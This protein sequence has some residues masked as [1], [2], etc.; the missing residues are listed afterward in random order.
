M[1]ISRAGGTATAAPLFTQ[2]YGHR[3]RKISPVEFARKELACLELVDEAAESFA[4]GRLAEFDARVGDRNCQILTHKVVDLSLD[5]GF[6]AATRR[7]AAR[8]RA[9]RPV[10]DGYAQPRPRSL[11]RLLAEAEQDGALL[12]LA[13]D[14]VLLANSYA[15]KK[16][17]RD[18]DHRC[19][20]R[21]RDIGGRR[22]F[23]RARRSINRL[24]D[25]H[26]TIVARRAWEYWAER[27]AESLAE[28]ARAIWATLREP[29]RVDAFYVRPHYSGLVALLHRI[30]QQRICIAVKSYVLL[31]DHLHV[32]VRTYVPNEDGPL[33]FERSDSRAGAVMA[34]RPA[35][36]VLG[37]SDVRGRFS[38]LPVASFYEMRTGMAVAGDACCGDSISSIVRRLDGIGIVDVILAAE[39]VRPHG[40]SPTHRL[41]ADVPDGVRA[42]LGAEFERHRE[43]ALSSGLHVDDASCFRAVHIYPDSTANLLAE[44]RRSG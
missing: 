25:S 19:E 10:L 18:G 15:V 44:R 36:V 39:A 29:D 24:T 30:W 12:D 32:V 43:L 2:L 16:I 4:R 17:T 6:V 28:D 37:L 27:G 33:R 22:A 23:Q 20:Q 40:E 8:V 31:P 14:H 42:R 26:L 13:R 35:V 7:L 11:T 3:P 21:I 34:D 9:I 38:G 1:T 5:P 41:T